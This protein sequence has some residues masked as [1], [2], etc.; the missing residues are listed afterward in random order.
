MVSPL[1]LAS[2]RPGDAAGLR[3][4]ITPCSRAAVI[5]NAQDRAGRRARRRAVAE[6]TEYVAAAGLVPAE[7]DLRSFR[8]RPEALAATLDVTELLWVAGGNVFVL[9]DA[10]RQSGLDV[11]LHGV[12]SP[13]RY[14]GWSAGAC[15]CGPTLHGLELVDEPPRRLDPIWDG[16]GLV[17]FVVVPHSGSPPPLGEE[18]A[19]VEA[20]LEAAGVPYRALRDGEAISVT[21]RQR[22]PSP[23]SRGGALR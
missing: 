3:E 1:L 5:L 20:H 8:G 11:A 10:M 21:A 15:V 13:L 23:G 7:L 4:F 9:R 19:R 14:V 6:E 12:T 2:S 18:I 16:L 17:D 22:P